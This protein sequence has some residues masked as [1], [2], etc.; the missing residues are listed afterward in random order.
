M[1]TVTTKEKKKKK[2]NLCTVESKCISHTAQQSAF[3]VTAQ[4]I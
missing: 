4:S 3:M 1:T 2:K